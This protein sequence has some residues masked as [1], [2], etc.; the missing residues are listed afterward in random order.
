MAKSD[1]TE[2]NETLGETAVHLAMQQLQDAGLGSMSWMGSAWTDAVSEMG[3]EV[4]SFMADR[5]R[6]D[7]KTQQDLLHC[8]TPQEVQRV[9]A[10]FV[11]K[12]VAQY[13]AETGKLFDMSA[14]LNPF[15]QGKS[16]HTPV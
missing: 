16:K 12:A 11:E 2:N 15:L 7:V 4:L 1:K 6:E 3:S 5:V 10:E 8:K 13:T 9:Q 14:A